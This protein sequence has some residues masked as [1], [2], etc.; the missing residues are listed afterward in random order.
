MRNLFLTLFLACSLLTCAPPM[1]YGENS[2]KLIQ[3]AKKEYETGNYKK[4]LNLLIKDLDQNPDDG[5][6]HYYMGLVRQQM[7]QDLPALKELELA[8]RLLP[9][10]TLDSFAAQAITEVKAGKRT[11][12]EKPKQDW[13]QDISNSVTEFFSGKPADS[14]K[15]KNNTSMSNAGS[16]K[17]V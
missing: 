11:L 8:A 2:E 12:P 17:R 10:E 14:S 3:Q 9:A 5:I 1:A 6:T 16:E 7:G 4:A 13:F 15:Q